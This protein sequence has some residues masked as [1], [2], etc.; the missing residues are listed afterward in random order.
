MPARS[1]FKDIIMSKVIDILNGKKTVIA[2][3]LN[4]VM[5]FV[6]GRNWLEPDTVTLVLSLMALWTG[7][8]VGHKFVKK[9]T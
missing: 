3:I 1:D 9:T 2:A 6:I 4:L 5:A 8:G 7:V